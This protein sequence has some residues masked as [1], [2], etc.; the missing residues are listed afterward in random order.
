MWWFPS[1]GQITPGQHDGDQTR[2]L[3]SAQKRLWAQRWG[4]MGWARGA[5]FLSHAQRTFKLTV[6]VPAGQMFDRLQVVCTNQQDL[7]DWEEHL[8][9][10]I[11]HT[12]S[13]GPSHK[14]LAVPCHTVRSR[15]LHTNAQTFFPS[16]L[17]H[18]DVVWTPWLYML[19][20]HRFS[21]AFQRPA[22]I[23]PGNHLKLQYGRAWSGWFL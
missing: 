9:R 18:P 20:S 15:W 21:S 3:W 13:T 17:L 10:Q 19:I 12:A 4:W 7:Q 23:V 14:P 22:R 5:V 1:A 8:P 16:V 2:R 6:S 11:K